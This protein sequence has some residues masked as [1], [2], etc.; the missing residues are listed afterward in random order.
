MTHA[1]FRSLFPTFVQHEKDQGALMDS[2]NLAQYM[3]HLESNAWLANHGASLDERSETLNRAMLFTKIPGFFSSKESLEIAKTREFHHIGHITPDD[4]HTTLK[5]VIAIALQNLP[6]AYNKGIVQAIKDLC[7]SDA[8]KDFSNLKF[9]LSLSL[10]DD[11]K[12][13]PLELIKMSA[14]SRFAMDLISRLYSFFKLEYL[15]QETA[16]T[17]LAKSVKNDN[18]ELFDLCAKKIDKIRAEEILRFI[19]DDLKEKALVLSVNY[20]KLFNKLSPFFS[21]HR[22]SAELAMK[23]LLSSIENK[24]AAFNWF[25]DCQNI[26]NADQ[27]SLIELLKIFSEWKNQEFFFHILQFI[28]GRSWDEISFEDK[29]EIGQGAIEHFNHY[30]FDSMFQSGCFNN[31]ELTGECLSAA[32]SSKNMYA[33]EKLFRPEIVTQVE[34]GL[35]SCAFYNACVPDEGAAPKFNI[36][37]IALFT[38]TWIES[39]D[40]LLIKPDYVTE[41]YEIAKRTSHKEV[42]ELIKPLMEF[43]SIQEL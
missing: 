3:S 35:L 34:H 14:D 9:F 22:F 21:R 4:S 28:H 42:L 26:A 32:C 20:E 27:E 23:G 31:V 38:K 37:A 1:A 41:L 15:D 19:P 11:Q 5:K 30:I 24:S 10:P 36:R 33:F 17:L 12:I 13:N 43:L 7:E 40:K 39:R 2:L 16:L 18:L 29:E 6:K 25:W 8:P